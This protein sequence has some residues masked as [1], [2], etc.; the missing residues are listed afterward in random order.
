MSGQD[1]TAE[2]L[3]QLYR[4]DPETG[5]F[6]R[7][8]AVRSHKPGD[9]VGYINCNGYPMFGID[10]KKVLAHRAAW[11]MCR[12]SIPQGMF[13]DHIN[14]DRRDN[15]LCNLRVASR[16][17]NNQNQRRARS[18][19]KSGA[20]GVFWSECR[21]KWVASLQVGSRRF[22]RVRS[23]LEDAQCAYVDLK[24]AHH[25]GCTI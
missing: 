4:Y 10:D 23:T 9:P 22:T 24:R 2:R 3:R 12:G 18:D 8:K 1:P 11:I 5:R 25:P 20:L 14:G 13:I 15:R 17:V 16:S 21:G 6:D 7:I 19:S